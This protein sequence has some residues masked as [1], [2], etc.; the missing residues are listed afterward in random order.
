MS[1]EPEYFTS[2]LYVAKAVQITRENIRDAGRWCSGTLT[3]YSITEL[4]APDGQPCLRLITTDRQFY[5]KQSLAFLGNWIVNIKGRFET[6]SDEEFRKT[7]F[8]HTEKTQPVSMER[9]SKIYQMV[10]QNLS[11]RIKN[12]DECVREAEKLS[13][14]LLGIT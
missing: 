6:F 9:Y 11:S 12:H 2:R 13:F 10:Y 14:D 5:S 8:H 7:F 1:I 3:D 4:D